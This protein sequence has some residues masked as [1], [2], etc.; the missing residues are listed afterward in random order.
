[1]TTLREFLFLDMTR[2]PPPPLGKSSAQLGEFRFKGEGKVM[3]R[4][5]GK[6]KFKVKG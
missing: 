3:G 6:V 5:K 4:V 2:E 1:M